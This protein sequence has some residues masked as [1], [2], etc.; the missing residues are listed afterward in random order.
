MK[1]YKLDN[2]C[3]NSKHFETIKGV[4][5]LNINDYKENFFCESA[6]SWNLN[7]NSASY[8]YHLRIYVL[9]A[10]LDDS[11]NLAI[12][13]K[14]IENNVRKKLI[15]RRIDNNFIRINYES[16]TRTRGSIRLYYQSEIIKVF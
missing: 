5:E 14:K 13:N 3:N 11:L 4:V 7:A 16:Q 12:D 9:D 1:T 2:I 6:F 8:R 15:D 10:R